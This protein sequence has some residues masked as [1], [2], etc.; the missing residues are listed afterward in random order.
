MPERFYSF[1][2][3]TPTPDGKTLGT[4]SELEL[5]HLEKCVAEIVAFWQSDPI[6]DAAILDCLGRYYLTTE[7]ADLAMWHNGFNDLMNNATETTWDKIQPYP[8]DHRPH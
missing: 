8:S 3:E 5:L 4:S 1:H 2:P 7:A 6:N